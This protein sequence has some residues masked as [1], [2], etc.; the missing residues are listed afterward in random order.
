MSTKWR[1][2]RTEIK[3]EEEQEIKNEGKN[4]MRKKR[5][6]E[7]NEQERERSDYGRK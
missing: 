2:G 7:I 3:W 1:G 5:A 4:R 6:K